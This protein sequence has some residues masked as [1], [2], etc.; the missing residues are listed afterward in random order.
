VIKKRGVGGAGFRWIYRD[1][2]R[3]A[4]TLSPLLSG[5]GLSGKM[6]RIGERWSE[7]A[8]LLKDISERGKPEK[9][10]LKKASQMAAGIY[11]METEYYSYVLEK[12]GGK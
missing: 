12:L 3:E 5:L 7:A 4:E 8:D 10:L 6:D 9:S 11:G 1:F 2:L